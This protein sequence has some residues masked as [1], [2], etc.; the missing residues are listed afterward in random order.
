M[1]RVVGDDEGIELSQSGTARLQRLRD[2]LHDIAAE[3][4]HLGM[5][6]DAAHTIAKIYERSRGIFLDYS[7]G[8]LR[9]SDGPHSLGYFDRRIRRAAQIE[10][11][12]A[13]SGI[14]IV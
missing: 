12:A 8:F 5:E 7:I 2:E 6:L 13:R 9:N 10:V 4:V 3:R 1:L 14:L 11:A